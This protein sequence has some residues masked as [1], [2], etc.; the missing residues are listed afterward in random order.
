MR[1]F[2]EEFQTELIGIFLI[3]LLLKVILLGYNLIGFYDFNDLFLG[4]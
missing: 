4:K 3:G 2:I 1:R